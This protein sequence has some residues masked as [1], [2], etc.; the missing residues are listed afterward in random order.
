MDLVSAFNRSGC[1][2]FHLMG[3]APALVM[4]DWP[5]LLSCLDTNGKPPWVFHSDIMLTESDYDP[6]VIT[7]IGQSRALYAVSVKGVPMEEVAR[8][9][10]TNRNALYKMMHDARLRLKARLEREGLRPEEL[11][12]MFGN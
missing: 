10:G 2:V 7:N 9:M 8:H 6:G 12:N 3:G 11:L 5:E 4:K 1:S